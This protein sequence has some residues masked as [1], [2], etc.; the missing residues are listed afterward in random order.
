MTDE[1]TGLTADHIG[2]SVRNPERSGYTSPTNIAGYLWST[3][4]VRDLGLIS[5]G[6]AHRRLS[7]TLRTL[8]RQLRGS[9]TERDRSPRGRNG[10][11]A[12]P[13]TCP[14]TQYQCSRKASG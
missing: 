5:R 13:R 3:I 10:S 14:R 8:G 4:V 1:T 12:R 11:I 2:V 9:P 7:Q 6:E